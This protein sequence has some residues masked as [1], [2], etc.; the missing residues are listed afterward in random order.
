MQCP[1]CQTELP[2]NAASC[3]RC[4]WVRTPALP[5]TRRDDWIAAL[6]CIVP[7]L[8]HLY[9][10]YLLP[11]LL[12]LCILGPAYLA[13]VF[14]LVPVTFGLSLLLPAIFVVITGIHAYRL[15]NVREDPGVLEQARRTAGRWFGPR[16]RKMQH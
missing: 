14:L 10:G 9:K 8:G 7:G 2:D 12:V 13:I 16:A 5:P 6:L 15:P 4:D 3:T 1:L 11:G